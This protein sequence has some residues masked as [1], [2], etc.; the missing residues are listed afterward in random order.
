[1]AII[2][3][4]KFEGSPNIIVWKHPN[5]A[6]TTSTRLIVNDSQEAVLFKDGVPC[7]LFGGGTHILE[8]KNIPILQRII[9]LPSGGES[10]YPAEVWYVNKAVNLNIRWG[11]TSPLQV[12]DPLFG[13]LVAVRANGQFGLQAED[14]RLLLKS[15]VGTQRTF[16][17]DALV[18]YFRG[19]YLSRVKDVIA[20]YMVF[21]G[22]SVGQI[23]ANMRDLSDY[24]HQQMTPIL[25]G[26]GLRLVNFDFNDISVDPDDPFIK[27]IQQTQV[28]RFRQGQLGYTYQEQQRL[29]ALKLAAQNPGGAMGGAVQSGMQLASM[30]AAMQM[31]QQ[32]AKEMQAQPS[33]P[34]DGAFKF[35]PACGAQIHADDNFCPRC[36]KKQ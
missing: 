12:Q 28:E 11:T 22:I 13:V 35:C 7:D 8:T 27:Q 1:M 32:L 31:G 14:S 17:T 33:A 29:E 3:V 34:Q 16:T 2:N 18:Q 15:L 21:R 24:V 36:G 23:N 25:A 30:G 19:L 5:S 10:R 20:N 26:Y 6:L 4:I 9:N